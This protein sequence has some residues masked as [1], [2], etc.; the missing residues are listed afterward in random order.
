V[1]SIFLDASY[2]LAVELVSDQ[3]HSRAVAHW[4]QTI[5]ASRPAFATTTFVLNEVVTYLNS[6]RL[7]AKACEVGDRLLISPNVRLYSVDDALFEQGWQ[8][9]KQHDD[10]TYSLTDCISFVLMR[11]VGIQTAFTF[12][13]H[14]QQ[15]GFVTE[16]L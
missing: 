7:H 5:A 6:R 8:F 16:P 4:T 9:M 2:L 11:Q 10:K 15:A 1:N 3:V 13:H 12:D 14:F